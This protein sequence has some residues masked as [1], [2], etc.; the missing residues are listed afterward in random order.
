VNR[1]TLCIAA[2]LTLAL[3]GCAGLPS[4]EGRNRSFA[5]EDTAGS[6]PLKRLWIWFLSVL[7]IEWLL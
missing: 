4:L 1:Q 6:G 5:V 3:A 7:P 2:V